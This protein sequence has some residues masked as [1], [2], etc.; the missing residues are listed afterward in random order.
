MSDIYKRLFLSSCDI[1]KYS[2]RRAKYFRQFA[3]AATIAKAVETL[4]ADHVKG[5]HDTWRARLI[6]QTY[7]A[8]EDVDIDALDADILVQVGL[9]GEVVYS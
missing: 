6:A 7:V 9:F 2:W 3:E 4:Q 8:A 1:A 5:L